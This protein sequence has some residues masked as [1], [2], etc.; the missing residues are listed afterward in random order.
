MFTLSLLMCPCMYTCIYSMNCKIHVLLKI[1]SHFT[2]I[3]MNVFMHRCMRCSINLFLSRFNFVTALKSTSF[4]LILIEHLLLLFLHCEQR[5]QWSFCQ[6]CICHCSEFQ[7]GCLC[8]WVYFYFI[9]F[10][11][12]PGILTKTSILELSSASLSHNS[13][14]FSGSG[15]H[16]Q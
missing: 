9:F 10:L 2:F 6:L 3:C 13:S 14:S 7:V 12:G 5:W 16:H 4:F 11:S 1:L 8:D 15:C